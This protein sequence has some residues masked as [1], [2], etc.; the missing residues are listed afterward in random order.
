MTANPS[1]VAQ[2]SCVWFACVEYSGMCIF[3]FFWHLNGANKAENKLSHKMSGCI[4]VSR[5]NVTQVL[6]KDCMFVV[7]SF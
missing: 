5:H 1:L 2:P 6:Y 7:I 4:L 3:S